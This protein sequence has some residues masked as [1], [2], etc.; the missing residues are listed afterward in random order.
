MPFLKN[1]VLQRKKAA[2]AV[3]Y[4]LWSWG[5][6]VSGQLAQNSVINRSSPVQVGASSDWKYIN[7]GSKTAAA[8][9]TDG[10]LWIWG[11]GTR[12]VLGWYPCRLVEYEGSMDGKVFAPSLLVLE[13]NEYVEYQQ[14]RN[15]TPEEIQQETDVQWEN[16]RSRRNQLLSSCDWTQLP[17]VDLTAELKQQW[18]DYRRDLRD[19]TNNPDPFNLPWPIEPETPAAAAS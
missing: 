14:V 15:K 6:N 4:N 16:V 13:G 3:N 2:A 5:A 10:S 11:N 1:I 18:I 19:I 8:I 9:K 12:G 7:S 17:D